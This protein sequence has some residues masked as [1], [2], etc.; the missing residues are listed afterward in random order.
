MLLLKSIIR[1]TEYVQS[2]ISNNIR[3]TDAIPIQA[4][5][6]FQHFHSNMPVLEGILYAKCFNQITL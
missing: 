1:I 6:Q 2:I 5:F 4:Y 3:K